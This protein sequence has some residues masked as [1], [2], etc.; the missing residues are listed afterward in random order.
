M[1]GCL[2]SGIYPC[3]RIRSNSTPTPMKTRGHETKPS[4]ASWMPA[5]A[6]RPARLTCRALAPDGSTVDGFFFDGWRTVR[7]DG[8]EAVDAGIRLSLD[9]APTDDPGWLIPGVF[10]GENRPAACI[11]TYPRFTAN[12]VDFER[13]ESD[14]WSFRADR[15]ST[16]AVFA[17]GGGLATTERSPLGQAGVG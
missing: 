13:M 3:G 9:L 17:A 16:P 12:H 15:C 11:R 5:D 14:T 1:Q 4:P 10:Y 7:Y 2:S 8:P 6:S